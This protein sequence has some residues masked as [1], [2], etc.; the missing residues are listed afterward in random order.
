MIRP[1]RPTDLDR[2]A[3]IANRAW[4]P[5]FDA[6]R[7]AYGD[8]LFAVLTPDRL[9]RKGVGVRRYVELHLG[10]AIVCEEGG[11]VV[12]FCTYGF[13]DERKIG[14]IN[15]NAADPE[16]GVKGVGQQMYRWVLAEFRRRGMRFAKVMTGL[17]E[18]HARARRAYERAGF[19]I[20]HGMVTYYMRL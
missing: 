1:L 11:E 12:G 4:Q 19:N 10:E 3:D 9:T 7:K 14:I 5:I 18:G 20:S 16:C 2:A 6:Y 13:D 8:A 17:D 15:N